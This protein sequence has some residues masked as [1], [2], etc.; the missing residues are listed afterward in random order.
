MFKIRDNNDP[1]VIKAQ[2]HYRKNRKS[3]SISKRG[4]SDRNKELVMNGGSVGG[5]LRNAAEQLFWEGTSRVAAAKRLSAIRSNAITGNQARKRALASRLA[6][7]KI[8]YPHESDD[9]QNQFKT[10]NSFY[11]TPPLAK[12]IINTK[13]IRMSIFEKENLSQRAMRLAKESRS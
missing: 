11:F 3:K 8:S 5:M 4:S 2:N 6:S 7:G 13:P 10:I 9:V 12:N 1:I